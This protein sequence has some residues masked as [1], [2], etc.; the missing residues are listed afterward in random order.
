M[1]I[2]ADFCVARRRGQAHE[3]HTGIPAEER[4]RFFLRSQRRIPARVPRRINA[5][6]RIAIRL[7]WRGLQTLLASTARRKSVSG[8]LDMMD[9]IFLEFWSILGGNIGGGPG[10]ELGWAQACMP[11]VCS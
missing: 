10:K 9:V 5:Q 8:T 4:Q 6:Y 11:C 1:D 2:F 7:S 3:L